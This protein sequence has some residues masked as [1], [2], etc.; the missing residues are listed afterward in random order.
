MAQAEWWWKIAVTLGWKIKRLLPIW[1]IMLQK[2]KNPSLVFFA[3]NRKH[4]NGLELNFIQPSKANTV[5]F[6]MDE[7]KEGEDYWKF[8]LIG[9]VIGVNVKFKSMETYVN[10]LWGKFSIP[11]VHLIK[12][13]LFLFEFQSE[14]QMKEILEAGP[15]FFGSRPF[16]LNHWSL[17]TDIEKIQDYTYPM[18]IQ[19]RN[20]KLNLWSSFGI[21]KIASIV[22]NPIAT[23]KLTATRERLSYAKVLI[24]VKLPLKE[25]LPDQIVIQGPDGKCYNQRIVYELKPRWCTNCNIIGHMTEQCRRQKMKKMWVPKQQVTNT[26]AAV[27][28]VNGS[29]KEINA[30]NVVSPVNRQIQEPI[31]NQDSVGKENGNSGKNLPHQ[32][33]PTVPSSGKDPMQVSR[34]NYMGLANI[35]SP[36]VNV[37]GFSSVNRAND[38]KR[39]SIGDKANV[40]SSDIQ[41]SQFSLLNCQVQDLDPSNLDRALLETKVASNKMQWIA[42]KMVKNWNWISNSHQANNGRIWILWDNNILS[43]QCI[44]STDQFISCNVNSKDGK[45]SCIITAVYALNNLEGR[46][47]LWH[48]LLSLK[49]N[50]TY[51]WIIGDAF[52]AII[53]NEEKLGGALVSDYDTED[54]I[55]FISTCQLIHLKTTGYFFTWNNKQGADSRIWSR[56]DR[57]LINEEWIQTY[58]SSQV[59][60]LVPNCSD[61]S[62]TLIT[63]G[64]DDFKGKRPFKFFSMW[65]NHPD[66]TTVVKTVWEQD[67]RGFHMY[68]L[69]TKLRELKQDLKDL[70]KKHFMNISEQVIRAKS[71]LSDIQNQL[72]NDLSTKC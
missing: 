70:N 44:S 67:I 22:G 23:D 72:N 60:Y 45:L 14:Y 51:P 55:N 46:K 41:A 71:E 52:N 29:E 53:S 28:M 17:D 57:V 19:L 38:A 26:L 36:T 40:A 13:G 16:V 58:T 61:H 7:W 32:H 27:N 50:V 12:Q 69:H 24:E 49:Q 62:H 63:I 18:W 65:I 37:S 25:P 42:R 47:E 30:Q 4:G 20:L 6:S 2:I 33:A 48:D 11:K 15:W 10:K 31:I 35:T 5:S 54:F 68:K 1:K 43:V 59:D 39:I 66:F 56:L 34:S 3:D 64:E 9:H 8:A 21:S